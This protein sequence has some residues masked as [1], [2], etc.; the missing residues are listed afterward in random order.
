MTVA[1][2]TAGHEV[3]TVSDLMPAADDEAIAACAESRDLVLITED[4]DFGRLAYALNQGNCGVIYVRWPFDA[5][6]SLGPALVSLASRLG[7]DLTDAFVV[8]TP[9]RAR[10]RRLRRE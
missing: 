3:L 7:Q 6:S 2:R 4:R 8:L 9:G 10:I 1:L 5:R